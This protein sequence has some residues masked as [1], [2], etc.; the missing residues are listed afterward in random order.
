MAEQRQ[1]RSIKNVVLTKKYHM[2]YMGTS[3]FLSLSLLAMIYGLFLY[4]FME[5]TKVETDAPIVMLVVITTIITTILGLLIIG[6]AVLAAHR[7]AGVH[8]KIRQ[9]C[10]K[11]EK[12][13]LD[14][15]IHFR[16]EDQLE[17]VQGAFNAMMDSLQARIDGL[18]AK[19]T[20]PAA[21]AQEDAS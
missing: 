1:R 10:E 5:L 9:I 13:D 21:E 7:I 12:G 18:G 6:A 3:V 16:K 4:R 19:E 14:A 8:I 20:T 15:R 2:P 17:E 11:I